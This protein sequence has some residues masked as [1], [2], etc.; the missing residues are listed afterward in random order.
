VSAA[1]GLAIWPEMKFEIP[2]KTGDITGMLGTVP[3]APKDNKDTK[4]T[5]RTGASKQSGSG[6]TSG[7]AAEPAR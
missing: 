5:G 2:G 4:D 7:N 1:K 3:N 6:T